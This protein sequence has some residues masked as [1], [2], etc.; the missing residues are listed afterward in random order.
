MCRSVD[1]GLDGPKSTFFGFAE[2]RQKHSILPRNGTKA[3][4]YDMFFSQ[5]A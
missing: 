2:H 4:P 3:V 1:F 5:Q